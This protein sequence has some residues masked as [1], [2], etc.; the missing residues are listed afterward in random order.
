MSLI[1]LEKNLK[2]AVSLKE[3]NQALEK[4]LLT[5]GITTFSFTYYS[6]Y[7]NSKNKL[8]YDFSS[9]DFSLWHKHYISEGYEDI[10]STLDSVYQQSLPIF[11][12][13]QDQLENAKSSRE[14]K[15]RLDSIKF[16]AEKG[17]S[18]PIHGP[19]EDFAILL[20]VQMKNQN[21]LDNWEELQYS[22][23]STAY[24]Y[25]FYLQKILLLTKPNLRKNILSQREIQILLLIAKQHSIEKIANALNITQRTV[26]YHIQ[27]LNK[28]LGVKNKYQAIIKAL[29]QN[30]IS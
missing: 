24:Y 16:G 18:I 4:Y 9:S 20:I 1:I 7:P 25:Y 17:L 5:F 22:L 29:K 15:M 27:K 12:D 28:K 14:K 2:K 30:L 11:W 21:C 23:F 26:N 13:L 19:Q 3:I 6:Y 10:D 8:K